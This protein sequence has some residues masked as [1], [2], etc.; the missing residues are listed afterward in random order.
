MYS[1]LQQIK[2][3]EDQMRDLW[4]HFCRGRDPRFIPEDKSKLPAVVAEMMIEFAGLHWYEPME[5]CNL[6]IKSYGPLNKEIIP[7]L[8]VVGKLI[9]DIED[10]REYH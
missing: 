9:M 1:K 4:A 3:P 7:F 6:L 5:L 8:L 2:T 10:N